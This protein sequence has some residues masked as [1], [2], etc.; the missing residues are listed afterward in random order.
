MVESFAQR[1]E[2]HLA[3][4]S[5]PGHGATVRLRLPR[6]VGDAPRAAISPKPAPEPGNGAHILLVEDQ[7]DLRRC[8]SASLVQLGYTLDTA[9]T[10]VAAIQRLETAG[11]FDLVLS[12]I[13]MPG[14]LSGIDLAHHVRTHLPG[15][16]IVL[17]TGFANLETADLDGVRVLQKPCPLS[18]LSQAIREALDRP[19][20]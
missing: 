1:A 19:G 8:I 3:I 10:A 9:P 16:A 15:T 7:E 20:R 2:G 4:Y 6:A 17:M 12:D 18:D 11:H 14:G 5:E 13:V